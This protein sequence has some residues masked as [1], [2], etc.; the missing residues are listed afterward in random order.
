MVTVVFQETLNNTA[1]GGNKSE[2]NRS[3][4]TGERPL[5][6]QNWATL[7]SW[8]VEKRPTFYVCFLTSLPSGLCIYINVLASYK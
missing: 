8:T 6:I 3:L 4:M 5:S 1:N 7:K 2:A